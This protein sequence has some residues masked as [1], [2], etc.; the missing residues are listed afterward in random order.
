MEFTTL[1]SEKEYFYNVNFNFEGYELSATLSKCFFREEIASYSRVHSHSGYEL[2]YAID[3]N[4]LAYVDGKDIKINRGEYILIYPN[5][6]HCVNATNGSK[7]TRCR[8]RVNN[9][10]KCSTAQN[11]CKELTHEERVK[12]EDFFE[13]KNQCYHIGY[14]GDI[15]RCFTEIS[16][17]TESTSIFSTSVIII[18]IK[19]ILIDILRNI[20]RRENKKHSQEHTIDY[21]SKNIIDTY[22]I[23]N[24]VSASISKEEL[25]NILC[26]SI[27]QLERILLNHY[28]QTFKDKLNQMRIEQA[29]YL[30]KNTKNPIERIAAQSGFS[31][32]AYFRRI[33]KQRTGCLPSIYRKNKLV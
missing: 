3:G 16:N 24:Y 9:F 15:A 20:Y 13:N 17:E 30:I 19:K 32:A 18:Y 7:S 27:R 8:L 5:V 28:G 33:F 21:D 14:S 11:N 31:N 29:K 2:H 25:A 4:L 22:F 6:I 23:K 12:L 10:G 1:L 26:V